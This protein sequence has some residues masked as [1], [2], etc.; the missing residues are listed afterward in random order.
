M[1]VRD[2]VIRMLN[3]I[4]K[5]ISCAYTNILIEILR[6]EKRGYIDSVD[7]AEYMSI[8]FDHTLGS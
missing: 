2:S 3:N 1:K 8:V 5:C 7:G 4:I 6:R